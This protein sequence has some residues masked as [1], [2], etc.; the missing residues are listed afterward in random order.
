MIEYYLF[1]K[2]PSP[3]Y[4]NDISSKAD[5]LLNNFKERYAD[6]AVIAA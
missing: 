6:Y 4:D 3:S 2:L 1:E 5:I